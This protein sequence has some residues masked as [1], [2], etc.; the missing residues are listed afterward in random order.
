[1]DDMLADSAQC[2]YD[3]KWTR[4]IAVGVEGFVQGIRDRLGVRAKGRNVVEAD[5]SYQL[6]EPRVP[7]SGILVPENDVLSAG[8]GR[9]WNTY[10]EMLTTLA[11]PDP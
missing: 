10:P 4:S 5:D 9:L 11:R 7:Y 1:M 8:N 3:S 2:L 6:R